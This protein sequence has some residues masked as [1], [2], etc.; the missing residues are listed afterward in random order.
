MLYTCSW[1]TPVPYERSGTV[2][3]LLFVCQ[4]VAPAGCIDC[5]SGDLLGILQRLLLVAARREYNRR[6]KEVVE[7]SWMAQESGQQ[8][9]GGSGGAGGASEAAADGVTEEE[10]G[11]NEDARE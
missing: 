1:R 4:C 7:S 3:L 10:A 6:V 2:L 8:P 11:P 9:E 5:L